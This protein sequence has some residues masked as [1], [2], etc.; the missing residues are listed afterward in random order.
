MAKTSKK[1]D[2]FAMFILSNGRPSQVKTIRTMKRVGYTGKYYIIVDDLDPSLEEYKKNHG[3]HV[4]VFNKKDY[5]DTTDTI[6]NYHTEKAVVYGRNACFDIAED[7][8][9]D[10]FMELDDDYTEFAFRFTDEKEETLYNRPVRNLDLAILLMIDVLE[11]SDALSI[12]FGQDGDYIGGTANN[13]LYKHKVIFKCMNSFLCSTKKRFSF[14]G[15]L[16]EDVNTVLH[17]GNRGKYFLT[18]HY[19]S[20]KQGTTQANEGGLTETYKDFGTYVKSFYSVIVRP[21]CVRIGV[22]GNFDLR[23]HHNVSWNKALPK[24][25]SEKYKKK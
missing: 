9:L 18:F 5:M 15:T 22:M 21:D 11:N 16:N 25:I 3:D 19:V 1:L 17:Y 4:I 23:V 2:N 7:L 6:D 14:K 10:Y 24:M 8:G 12:A 20:V 13:T